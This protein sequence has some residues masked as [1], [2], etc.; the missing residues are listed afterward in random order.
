MSNSNNSKGIQFP[1][2]NTPIADCILEIDKPDK[3]Q[4]GSSTADLTHQEINC[5]VK[6]FVSFN[7][8]TLN[9]ASTTKTLKGIM[10]GG[11]LASTCLKS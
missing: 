8:L 10:L 1:H 7:S 2:A 4:E 5:P 11:K 9:I 3:F 6:V